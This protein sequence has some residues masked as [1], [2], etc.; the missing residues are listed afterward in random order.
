MGSDSPYAASLSPKQGI[1][2]RVIGDRQPEVGERAL[3]LPDEDAEVAT[4][5][6]ALGKPN[7]PMEAG[8]AIGGQRRVVPPV[9]DRTNGHGNPRAATT[10]LTYCVR[11]FVSPQLMV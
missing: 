8:L 4:A 6:N 5:L 2:R 9:E 7:T 1:C 3:D 11:R 10:P